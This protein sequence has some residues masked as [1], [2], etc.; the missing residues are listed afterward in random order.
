M[1][2]QTQVERFAPI[3]GSIGAVL[4][5]R[6]LAK[7]AMQSDL[8]GQVALVDADA[9]AVGARRSSSARM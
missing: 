7:R 4:A 1:S 8:T 3:A 9:D 2:I 6:A 5:A